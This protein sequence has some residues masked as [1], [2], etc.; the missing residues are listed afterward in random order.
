MPR[1][2]TTRPALVARI[3]ENLFAIYGPNC[4]QCGTPLD[5][6]PWEVNHIWGRDWRP[7]KLNF[8]N[9][10]LRYWKEAQRGLID[11]RCRDCNSNYRPITNPQP[12]PP[13]DYQCPRFQAWLRGEL[14]EEP[15]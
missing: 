6:E 2:H 3:R 12:P 10:H 4:A 8:Y 13:P 7:Q 1:D 11:L 5:S 14:V 15:F 9:R